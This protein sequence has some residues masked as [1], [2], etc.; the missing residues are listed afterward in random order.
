MRTLDKNTFLRT[1]SRACA[2][3][4]LTAT[5]AIAADVRSTTYQLDIPAQSLGDA[6]QT[7]AL[8]SQHKLLYDTILVKGKSSP[9]LK[10]DFTTEEAVR[11]LLSGTDLDY[12]VTE[13]GLV[14]IRPAGAPPSPSALHSDPRGGYQGLRL[15]NSQTPSSSEPN[16]VSPVSQESET[17]EIIVLGSY[18]VKDKLDTATGLGL[19]TLETPQSVTIMTS[20]RIVDQGLDSLTDI[21]KNAPGISG[22]KLDSN[23]LSYSARGFQIDNFLVDGVPLA[24]NYSW[25][26]GEANAEAALYERIEVVRGATGLLTGAGNPSAAI[27]MV[28]KRATSKEFAS[29]VMLEASRWNTLGGSVDLSLPLNRA[30]SVRSR[31]VAV[32][33]ARDGSYRDAASNT[34]TVLYGVVDADLTPTTRLSAGASYQS[35]DESGPLWGGLPAFYSDGTRTNWE[36]SKTTAADWTRVHTTNR[37]FFVNLRHEFGNGWEAKVDYTRAQNACDDC[38]LLFAYDTLDRASGTGLGAFPYWGNPEL[39]QTDISLRLVGS[40]GLFGR[41]HEIAFGATH[42]EQDVFAHG[43]FPTNM[44]DI[45]YG[46]YLLWDGAT[47]VAPSWDFSSAW[48]DEDSNI[49]QKGVYAVTRLAL[50]DSLKLIAGGRIASWERRGDVYGSQVDFGNDEVVI[51]YGGILYDLNDAHRLYV[52]YTEIF[53][54]Q[55]NRDR[56]GNFLDPIAGKSY[57]VGLKSAYFD[58]ALQTTATFFKIL[59]DNLAQI[60]PGF[61]VPNT[62]PPEQASRGAQGAGS[63]GFELETVG[64]LF[65][66]FD[67]SFGYTQFTAEDAD[68][69]AVNTDHPR[70]LVKLFATWQH[71]GDWQKLTVGGGVVWE[72]RNYTDTLNPVTGAP[73]RLQQDAFSLVNLMVRYDVTDRFVAQVNVHN[74]LDEIYYSQIGFYNQL[75]YGE[76]RN[77]ALT[78]SYKF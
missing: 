30:G 3:L 77:V 71:P 29:V 65:S 37:A 10:G 53:K 6:L 78:M 1:L 41:Q 26:T 50:S 32:H 25:G 39:K 28:R 7:L 12:E 18:T 8:A 61:T 73:E 54:P 64:E 68:D 45:N 4:F 20:Q 69:N 33:E 24:W 5:F 19:T 38:R 57:E 35:N 49:K 72:D 14:L 75:A 74:V 55:N 21:V 62:N 42:S 15:A 11:K 46:N 58:G 63:K 43:L 56:Y 13:D 9:A 48:V 67:V 40:V 31:M 47:T 34:K 44:G 52:S 59:Q 27:N 17:G 51:P 76:P 23:A 66:G 60:D 2:C 70:K 22:K 16:S 36:R